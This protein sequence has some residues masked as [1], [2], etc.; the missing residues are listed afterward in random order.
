MVCWHRLIC[1]NES[2]LNAAWAFSVEYV[3]RHVFPSAFFLGIVFRRLELHVFLMQ[4]SLRFL[5]SFLRIF[6]ADVLEELR[7]LLFRELAFLVVADVIVVSET[8]SVAYNF[9]VRHS[10]EHLVVICFVCS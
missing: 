5:S 3:C 6:H 9:A 2:L 7:P 4:L 1:V 10:H 8:D